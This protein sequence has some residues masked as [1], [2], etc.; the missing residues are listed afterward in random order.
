MSLPTR[1]ASPGCRPRREEAGWH[2][3]FV[4]DH[5]R[6]RE[7]VVEVADP[8]IMRA[9]VATS[10][11]RVRPGPMVTAFLPR[12]CSGR[13]CRCG[14]RGS[15]ASPGRCAGTRV[16]P[17]PSHTT[18]LPPYPP[19]IRRPTPRRELPG[20]SWSSLGGGIGGSGAWGDPRRSRG[21]AVALLGRSP[22]DV[23]HPML[24]GLSVWPDRPCQS[25]L[26]AVSA[27]A[28]LVGIGRGRPPAVPPAGGETRDLHRC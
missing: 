7:P 23:G 24:D 28:G 2:G 17:P 14:S 3:V 12:R 8:W 5:A 13:A 20:G 6:W 11:E 4:W 18:S 19:A 27:A 10:T 15:T 1:P 16:G 25:L 26:P 22:V 9:A 21:V